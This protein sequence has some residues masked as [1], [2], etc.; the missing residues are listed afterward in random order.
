VD[1]PGRTAVRAARERLADVE[2]RQQAIEAELDRAGGKT[3]QCG[4][5]R[6]LAALHERA[7]LLASEHAGA[8]DALGRA[9]YR[10]FERDLLA[11]CRPLDDGSITAG[12]VERADYVRRTCISLLAPWPTLAAEAQ[13]RFPVIHVAGRR[14]LDS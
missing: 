7:A 3:S 9:L 11:I 8:H 6:R 14:T 5:E 4:D 13:E 2:A 10:Q 1:D 12:L